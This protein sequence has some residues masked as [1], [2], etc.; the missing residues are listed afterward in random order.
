MPY[1]KIQQN[2]W[3][4]IIWVFTNPPESECKSI[5]FH[6]VGISGSSRLW[7]TQPSLVTGNSTLTNDDADRNLLVQPNFTD[8][9]NSNSYWS[10][11]ALSSNSYVTNVSR[12]EIVG[13]PSVSSAKFDMVGI[14]TTSDTANIYTSGSGGEESVFKPLAMVPG[15]SY[16]L[17]LQMK[18]KDAPGVDYTSAPATFAVFVCG[19]AA[20]ATF[21]ITAGGGAWMQKQVEFTLAAGTTCRHQRKD[22]ML[23]IRGSGIQSAISFKGMALKRAICQPAESSTATNDSS[24]VTAPGATTF[25]DTTADTTAADTLTTTVSEKESSFMPPFPAAATTA[26][27]NDTT[28]PVQEQS[29]KTNQ[30]GDDD[31][32]GGDSS[33]VDLNADIIRGSNQADLG[34]D[35]ANS[36]GVIAG[37]VLGIF[38]LVVVCAFIVMRQRK[39]NNGDVMDDLRRAR[40]ATLRG[41]AERNARTQIPVPHAAHA[42]PAVYTNATYVNNSNVGNY[43]GDEAHY[44]G[45]GAGAGGKSSHTSPDYA[46]VDEAP[47]DG[48]GGETDEVQSSYSGLEGMQQMYAS[49]QNDGSTVAAG[50][51]ESTYAGLEGTQQMYSSATETET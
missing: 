45:S 14:S 27:T 46:E 48:R 8:P 15:G 44:E 43:G 16:V 12:N 40:A 21:T 5:S 2:Q 25:A 11:Q 33:S 49:S 20:R 6:Y 31:I 51:A 4:K 9:S 17:S 29:S 39:S 10:P 19:T 50:S 28:P 32:N 30:P 36:G 42:R 13:P 3:T 26:G 41:A 38:L 35:R 24:T 37:I 18:A 1:Q 7:L 47:N 34:S 22:Y 23:R